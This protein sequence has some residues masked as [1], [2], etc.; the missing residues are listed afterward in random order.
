LRAK[1]RNTANPSIAAAPVPLNLSTI[2]A[3][4]PTADHTLMRAMLQG[5]GK[6]FEALYRRHQANVYRFAL[7]RS[8]SP[9]TA[10]DIVQDVFMALM[11][12]TLKYDPLK[13]ALQNFLV[14][15][16]R[17]LLLKRDE[18][19]A[20]F[21]SN[22]RLD[23][24]AEDTTPDTAPTPLERLLAN[25][26]SEKVRAALAALAPHYRDV[27]ILF[28][29]HDLSYV[30]IAHLCGIDI[31]TVRSRLSR[32]RAKLLGML[33]ADNNHPISQPREAQS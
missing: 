32:A 19:A 20:R 6:A 13:G 30:E 8:G 28:E 18:A 26:T 24:D 1:R 11:T 25:E 23:D 29:M 31:G 14:G 21:V 15:V 33:D 7:L 10:C 2:D 27:A 22:T 17:N 9:D 5:D 4:D 12:G 16:A 3:N